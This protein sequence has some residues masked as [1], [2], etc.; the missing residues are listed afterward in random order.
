MNEE[1]IRKLVNGI[2]VE[3]LLD[4]WMAHFALRTKILSSE[5]KICEVSLDKY[6]NVKVELGKNVLTSNV[7]V[8]CG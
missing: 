2:I 4:A 8:Q 7:I 6:Y 3:E 1:L 5:Q